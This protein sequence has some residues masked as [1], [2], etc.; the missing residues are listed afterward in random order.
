MGHPLATQT[1]RLLVR[2]G[3]GRARVFAP[4]QTLPGAT[5]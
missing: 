1:V 4:T 2:D 5:A 3:S